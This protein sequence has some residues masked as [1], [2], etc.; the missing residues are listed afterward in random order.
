MQSRRE[1]E[2]S[3]VLDMN[4]EIPITFFFKSVFLGE[5]LARDINL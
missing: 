2:L 4:F 3:S 5:V 1:R